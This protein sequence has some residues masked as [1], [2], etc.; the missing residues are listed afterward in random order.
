MPA[1]PHGIDQAQH[2]RSWSEDGTM[3]NFT[4]EDHIDVIIRLLSNVGGDKRLI[5]TIELH[6]AART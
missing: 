4:F 1:V 6:A 5:R 2:S 3:L